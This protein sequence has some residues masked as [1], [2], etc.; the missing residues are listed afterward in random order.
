MATNQTPESIMQDAVTRLR[1]SVSHSDVLSFQRTELKD[2][3][4]AAEDI[5]KS[6]RQ[7]GSLQALSRI[8]PLLEILERYS[9]VIEI[10]CNGT[11]YL[12]W[13]WVSW[14]LYDCHPSLT[15]G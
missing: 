5:Q 13:V 1:D 4:N 2:V 7:R 3:W 8:Q 6:Q 15:V 14:A 11:P 12:P 10:L 9:R